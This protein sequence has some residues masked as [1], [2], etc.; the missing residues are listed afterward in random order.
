MRVHPAGPR[1]GELAHEGLHGGPP[2]DLDALDRAVW[3][4]GISRAGAGHLELRGHDVR[5]LVAEHGSPAF[6][7]DEADL[8]RRCR[9]YREAF[10]GAMVF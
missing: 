6:L 9:D 7:M 2:D 3:P 4:L 8:R 5:D 1:S 10:G